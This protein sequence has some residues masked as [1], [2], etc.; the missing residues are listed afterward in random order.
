MNSQF[1]VKFNFNDNQIASTNTQFNPGNG[2]RKLRLL[3]PSTQVRNTNYFLIANYKTEWQ[4]DHEIE[5]GVHLSRHDSQSQYERH[6]HNEI[7]SRQAIVGSVN[8][9][10]KSSYRLFIQDD[11]RINKSWALNLGLA[12]EQ[13]DY[14]LDEKLAQQQRHYQIWRP[15]FIC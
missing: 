3:S 7:D 11:W 12:T 5:A 8:Q 1:E 2:H 6:H 10:K 14:Q 4:A 9:I 15:R 13:Q